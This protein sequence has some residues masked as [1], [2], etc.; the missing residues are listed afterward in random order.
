[1]SSDVETYNIPFTLTEPRHDQSTYWGRVQA[2]REA[3]DMR[4]AFVANN[5]VI[6]QYQKVKDQEAREKL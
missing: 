4:Y 6:E 2:L 3:A 1:M 5:K